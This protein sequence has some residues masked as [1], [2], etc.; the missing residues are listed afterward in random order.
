MN[1]QSSLFAWKFSSDW[2]IENFIVKSFCRIAILTSFS[3]SRHRQCIYFTSFHSIQLIQLCVCYH[4]S[5]YTF[6]H[7]NK[8]YAKVYS[9]A[10]DRCYS[11][12]A[13]QFHGLSYFYFC[14]IFPFFPPRACILMYVLC[15]P[16]S[17]VIESFLLRSIESSYYLL[18]TIF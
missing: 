1:I 14:L 11:N 13:C 2:F 7:P 16:G 12:N 8:I 3:L 10:L 18:L 6:S 9:W 5:P 4:T 17:Q 15:A